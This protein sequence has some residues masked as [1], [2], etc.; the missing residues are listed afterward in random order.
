MASITIPGNSVTPA[1]TFTVGNAYYGWLSYG[2]DNKD[3]VYKVIGITDGRVY[4]K[5]MF[6]GSSGS[7][8][9]KQFGVLSKTTTVLD[10]KEKRKLVDYLFTHYDSFPFD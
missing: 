4:W 1:K 2:W 5:D 7:F 10:P 8:G 9:A 6:R 3:M